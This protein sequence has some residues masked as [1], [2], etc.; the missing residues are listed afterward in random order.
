MT[1]TASPLATQ[2]VTRIDLNGDLGEGFDD[3]AMLPVLSSANISCGVHAGGP[4]VLHHT[5]QQAR[6]LGVQ[7][8]AH[9]S[10]PDRATFGRSASTLNGPELSAVLIYQIAAFAALNGGEV[11][12]LKAHGALYHAADRDERTADV[13][14]SQVRRVSR[15]CAVLHSPGGRVEQACADKNVPFIAEAFADRAYNPDGTLVPRA[16]AGAVLHDVD[17][18]AQR[19]LGL[20]RG[21]GVLAFDGSRVALRADSI[22][23]HGDSPNA[24][25]MATRLHAALTAAGVTIASAR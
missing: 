2:P 8:G 12:Y 7:V 4:L 6:R 13:L 10:Y 3:A 25:Q 21:E 11:P 20:V 19:V 1:G 15:Q 14:V 9:V 5:L 18:V 16:A 17:L 23:V 24:V 22:C